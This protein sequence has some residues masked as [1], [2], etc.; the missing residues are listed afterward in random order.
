MERKRETTNP[1]R[2]AGGEAKPTSLLKLLRL[3]VLGLWT[4]CFSRA[5]TAHTFDTQANKHSAKASE[6]GYERKD[7][8][9]AWVFAIVGILAV[10][11]VAIHLMLGAYL[12]HLNGKAPPGDSWQPLSRPAG[13]LVAPVGSFPRLQVSPPFDLAA[14]RAR[15]DEHLNSYGWVNK[16]SGTVHIPISVAMDLLLKKGLPVRQPGNRGPSS[17]EMQL[18]RVQEQAPLGEEKR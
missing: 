2:R 1:A 3:A 5:R 10:S 6:P 9:V 13:G 14:F 12:H 7:A 18:K 17:Y 16:T 8:S 15:E 11:G 4:F